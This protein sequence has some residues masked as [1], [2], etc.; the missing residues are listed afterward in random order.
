MKKLLKDWVVKKGVGRAV[1]ITSTSFCKVRASCPPNKHRDNNSKVG[2]KQS[3]RK[4][5]TKK[6]RGAMKVKLA[7]LQTDTSCYLA[8]C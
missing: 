3:R 5:G 2:K 6:L 4:T 7:N 1:E 8:Y